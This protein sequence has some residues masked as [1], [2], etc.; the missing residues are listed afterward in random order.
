LTPGT[1][2]RDAFHD[3]TGKRADPSC[4]GSAAA[5]PGIFEAATDD[6]S[7]AIDHAHAQFASSP[8][9]DFIPLFVEKRARQ[10]LTQGRIPA[11][12]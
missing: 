9:R 5:H 3:E 1:A 6:V 7:A 2:A 10:A 8:I 12:A 11:S 4:R